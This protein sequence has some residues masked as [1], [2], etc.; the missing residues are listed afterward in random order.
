MLLRGFAAQL[1]FVLREL[2]FNLLLGFAF[3]NHFFAIPPQEIV[4]RFHANPDGAGGLVFVEVFEGE[5]GRAGL[6]DDA[7]NDSV[8]GRVVAALET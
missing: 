6:L 3:A 8:N 4:D 7:F 5:I 1:R 2:R